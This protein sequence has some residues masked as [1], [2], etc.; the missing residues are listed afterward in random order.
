M[1]LALPYGDGVAG[2][3]MQHFVAD[4][5]YS[6]ACMAIAYFEAFMQMGANCVFNC[7]RNMMGL[8]YGKV[9]GQAYWGVFAIRLGIG[10]MLF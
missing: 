6:V 5:E 4:E 8:G 1:K 3:A 2:A 10:F 9:L 7:P